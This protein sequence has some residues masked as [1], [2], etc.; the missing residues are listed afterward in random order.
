MKIFF[1]FFLKGEGQNP[2]R[3]ASIKAGLPN[4]V[5]A[6]VVNMLCGSGLRAVVM[7]AQAIK[8]GDSTI[9]VAG[10]MEN[11]SRVSLFR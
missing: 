10:G 3:Q 2:A 11:M 7:G 6:C 4:S 5:P 9:V 1:F 8:T